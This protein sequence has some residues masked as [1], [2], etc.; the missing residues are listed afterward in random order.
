MPSRAEHLSLSPVKLT[1]EYLRAIQLRFDLFGLCGGHFELCGRL[2]SELL[3]CLSC[4]CSFSF[5]TKMALDLC[6]H[7]HSIP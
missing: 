4:G 1:A 2:K 3:L 7:K 5:S 6:P